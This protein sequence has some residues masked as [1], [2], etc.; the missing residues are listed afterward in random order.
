MKRKS[1]FY[2]VKYIGGRKWRIA[3]WY[4]NESYWTFCGND[5]N[6]YDNEDFGEIDERQIIKLK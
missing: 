1:G 2:W 5:D 4:A 3:E 6:Y